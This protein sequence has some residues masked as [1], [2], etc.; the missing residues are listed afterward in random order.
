MKLFDYEIDDEVMIMDVLK[1][2]A[3]SKLPVLV[4]FYV[5]SIGTIV[6]RNL[7]GDGN[8]IYKV[9]GDIVIR[10]TKSSVAQ[11]TYYYPQVF[12]KKVSEVSSMGVKETLKQYKTM[13][14]MKNVTCAN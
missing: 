11:T 10:A 5:G 6:Q 12:L 14:E 9:R 3:F 1:E 13:K 4:P 2:S 8:P 7:D